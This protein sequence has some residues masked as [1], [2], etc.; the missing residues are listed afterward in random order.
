M[1]H[2]LIPDVVKVAPRTAEVE[3]GRFAKEEQILA[4]SLQLM[5]LEQRMIPG[6]PVKLETN[7]RIAISFPAI[8]P[9]EGYIT[10][11]FE[12]EHNHFGLD[13]AG[14]IGYSCCCCC[15]WKYCFFWLDI[16][17]WVCC[18]CVAYE[19]FYELLQAQSI[20]V[21]ICWFVCSARRANCDIRQFWNH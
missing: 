2:C 3:K 20:I 4:K 6:R 18:D 16:Q 13:I 15:R 14:K 19:W 7:A 11:G 5:N 21:K 12:P 8:L 9:T 17:R 1:L 10:Q